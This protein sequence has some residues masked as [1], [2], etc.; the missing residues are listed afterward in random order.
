MGKPKKY[1]HLMAICTVLGVIIACI[2]LVY[3]VYDHLYPEL[4]ETA[5]DV[6]ITYPSNFA[7]VNMNDTLS[8]IAKNIPEGNELYIL[9]YPHGVKKYYPQNSKMHITD[10]MWSVPIWFGLKNDVGEQF[11]I[12][13]VTAD[14]DAQA[15]YTSYM[16]TC[17][18]ANN[19]PGLDYIPSGS[20]EYDKITVIR[21]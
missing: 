19:W 5:T 16:K 6:K 8:G 18:K 7:T 13:A 10:D 11:D 21:K 12:I 3:V 9:V 4:P 20:K 15:A 2:G 17:D 1:E 14:K